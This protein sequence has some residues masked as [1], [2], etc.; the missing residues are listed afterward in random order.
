MNEIEIDQFGI[1]IT[2]KC[3]MQCDFCMRGKSQNVEIN[4]DV[5]SEIF[6]S[7]SKFETIFATRPRKNLSFSS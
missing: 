4:D 5:I 2:R 1:E 3:N 6:D 7:L